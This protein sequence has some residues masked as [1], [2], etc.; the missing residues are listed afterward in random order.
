MYNPMQSRIDSL[1]QQRQMIDQQLNTLQQYQMPSININNMP[2]TPVNYDF[3]GKWVSNE[4]EA[5]SVTNNNLPLILFDKNEPMFYMKQLNGDMKKFMF[6]EVQ[7]ST[8]NPSDRIDA[9]EKKL[10]DLISTMTSKTKKVSKDEQ[11]TV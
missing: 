9:L 6:T 1:M 4:N 7:E 2:Q 3:N 5:R 8:T 11:P 10:D